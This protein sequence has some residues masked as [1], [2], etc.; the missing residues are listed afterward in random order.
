MLQKNVENNMDTTCNKQGNLKK[1]EKKNRNTQHNEGK[2]NQLSHILRG[3]KYG[4]MRLVVQG[5]V[6]GKRG[7]GRRRTSWLKNLRQWSGKTSI[8][9]FRTAA[10]RIKWAMMNANVLKG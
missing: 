3:D 5:K 2:E 7:P 4:L 8:K 10:D 6:K 1:Y 9:L